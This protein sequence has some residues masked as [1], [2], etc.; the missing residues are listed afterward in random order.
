V[1]RGAADARDLGDGAVLR[2]S[3]T[4]AWRVRSAGP[5]RKTPLNALFWSISKWVK[6]RSL[7]V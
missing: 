5:N 2:S 7:S 4:Q 3:R 6:S 1:Q